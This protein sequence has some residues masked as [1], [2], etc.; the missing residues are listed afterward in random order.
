MTDAT[1]S[2][3]T[4][5]GPSG[6][7]ASHSKGDALL[8]GNALK[9]QLARATRMTKLRTFGLVVPLL[10]F[11]LIFFI[12][13]IAEMLFRSVDNREL[14]TIWPNV[15]VAIEQWDGEG[16]PDEDVFAALGKDL[17]SSRED[18][19][20]GKA[21]TR[22][23]RE[24]GGLRSLVTRTGRAAVRAQDVTSW[25]EWLIDQ[26][27]KWGEQGVWGASKVATVPFTAIK[28]LY[29]VDLQI[30]RIGSIV[31]QPEGRQI[32]RKLFVRR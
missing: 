14:G 18:R 26:N 28:Y 22:L 32:Y 29:S 24:S 25:K 11:I 2:I 23:N 1:A 10:A 13:P 8:Q 15:T 7:T 20:I 27:E 31:E 21:A 4:P 16:I 9:N 19:T 5:T 6:G 12:F 3:D 30:D 17:I